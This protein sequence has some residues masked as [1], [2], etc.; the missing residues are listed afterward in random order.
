MPAPEK[1]ATK[2]ATSSA[3]LRDQI[4]KA[5]AAKRAPGTSKSKVD[6]GDF[7][8][9][10]FGDPFNTKPKDNNGLLRK[11]IDAARGDGRL[12]LAG[13]NLKKIPDEILCMYDAEQL[14][15]SN[16]S[17]SQMVDLFR[18]VAA[19]NELDTIPDDIF[20]DIAT[21]TAMEDESNT[22]A[23]QFR[24]VEMVDLHGN[25]LQA[26]P[27]GLR[28]LERLTVLNLVSFDTLCL[29]LQYLTRS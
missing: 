20:P 24:G 11:R 13:L 1:A 14:E 28:R 25:N 18:F 2:P 16:M 19:D 3:A 27:P 4:A 12:N 5:K 8:F 7:Q 6:A 17:W 22:K 29:S 15:A 9:D 10:P 21:E 23:L 26:I